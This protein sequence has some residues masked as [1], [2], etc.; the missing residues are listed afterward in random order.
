MDTTNTHHDTSEDAEAPDTHVQTADNTQAKE[1]TSAPA[2]SSPTEDSPAATVFAEPATASSTTE[3]S[4]WHT[5]L[6]S[7]AAGWVATAI[8]TI[9]AALIRLPGLDN[10]RTLVF[11]ETY[12][13]KDAWSLLTLGYEGTW[14]NNY[15]A[16]FVAGNVSGLS[17]AGGYPVHPPTGK[18][19]IAIGMKIF[20]QTDPVGWRI[21]TAICG[22]I[23]V[24][25]LCR[26]TQNLFRSPA[27]T[28]LAGLFLA[29]DGIAIVMS[30]TSILDG[31]LAMFALAAFFCFVKDQQMSRPMLAHRLTAWDGIG[32]P[33]GGWHDL[34]EFLRGRDRRGFMV[35]PNAGRRPWLL[36]VG[37]LCGLA[38]S[39]K[40]SG[41]YV[42]A[43]LGLFVAIREVTYRWRLGH[44]SPIRGALI[45][46]VWWAFILMVPSAILTYIASW[47]GWFMHPQAH[48]HGRSGIPGFAG[49]LADLW[50]YHKEMWTFHTGLTTPHTYQS[51]PYM[52]L[53]QVRP[54]SFHWAND[55]TITGCAS[56]NCATN[57]VALGNPLLWWIGI[58]AL[59]VAIVATLW[60]HSGRLSRAVRSVASLHS[61]HDL[62]L[63]HGRLRPLRS[64]RGRLDDLAA[65]RVRHGGWS[66]RGCSP[67]ASNGDHRTHHGR[68][69]HRRDPR[70]CTLLHAAVA[71]RRRRLRLLAGTH[72]VAVLDLN[73]A[74]EKRVARLFCRATRFT[75][76]LSGRSIQCQHES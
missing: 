50:L 36:A 40:W 53:T 11:D 41:I 69:P 22:I 28:L 24:F 48:G 71:R 68:G 70:M 30:R 52:W 8:A 16:S 3:P 19:I 10:V 60:S 37:I 54:T 18:W 5:R 76:F 61:P 6:H 58:G 64:P 62:H 55:A 45:A 7:P 65:R 14:P 29:T 46:D 27:F 47:I 25:L 31:F 35:G 12:Y 72:V 74:Y 4:P 75:T 26:I 51:N 63:L 1:T 67:A 32:A 39:V 49:A 42:L 20:G 33:R 34:G 56:G 2:D 17:A 9:V 38:S 21:T 13:V 23:T 73:P 15:D 66:P 44:P 43:C 57:V 59:L